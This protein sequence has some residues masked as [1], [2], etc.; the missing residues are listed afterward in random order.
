[1]IPKIIH[2]C[3]FGGNPLPELAQRCI[4]SWKKYCP[5]YEIKEWNEY[6]FDLTSCDYVREA[7][8]A[9]KWA[10]VTDYVR[11]YAM[12]REGGI[13]MDTDVE[14]IKSLD[15]FLNH[16]AF[17]GF[18]D[19]VNIQTGIMACEKGFPLFMELL[20]DYHKRHFVLQDGKLDLTT[21]VVTITNLCKKYGFVANNTKQDVCGFTLY[22]HDVFCP[23]SH[24]TGNISLTSRTVTIHYFSGSWANKE[25]RISAYIKKNMNGKSKLSRVFFK[26]IAFPFTYIGRAKMEGIVSATNYYAKK[27]TRKIKNLF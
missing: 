9:K 12:V 7:Y 6:N 22:P 4:A 13:Y 19:E 24:E 25:A 8:E 11:L 26:T 10:F 16:R 5:D 3:W 1:M 15:P 27:V 23:K 14:V 17:S 18:E 21:N 20:E 2:Y